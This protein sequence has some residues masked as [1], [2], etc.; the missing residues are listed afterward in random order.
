MP[1]YNHMQIIGHLG[2][3]P[4]IRYTQDSKA[5]ANF[6]V[7]VSEKYG[8]NE[9]TEWFSVVAWEKKAEIA[10]KFLHKGDAVFVEGKIKTRTWEKDGEKKKATELIASNIVLLG[11][12]R[13][14]REESSHPIDDNDIPF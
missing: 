8:T 5:V 14:P 1:N 3:D 7:A 6:S 12:K 13:E 4:E 11:G 10:Q 2:R 9:S